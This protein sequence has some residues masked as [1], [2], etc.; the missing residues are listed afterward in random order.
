MEGVA[1]Y[2]VLYGCGISNSYGKN[3]LQVVYPI[4]T[5]RREVSNFGVMMNPRS[6]RKKKKMSLS[7]TKQNK[8]KQSETK[9]RIL[10]Y[11]HGHTTILL[12]RSMQ[13]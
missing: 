8:T 2:G 6:K 11:I 12:L 13:F 5:Q 1:Q 9:T 4:T 3:Q 7:E 10:P